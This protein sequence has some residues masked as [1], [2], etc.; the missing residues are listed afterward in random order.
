MPQPNTYPQQAGAT[1]NF[2]PYPTGN[3]MF[4][5]SNPYPGGQSNTTP[6]PTGAQNTPYPPFMPNTGGYN[7]SYVSFISVIFI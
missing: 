5:G 1:S 6:Y 7:T 2:P 4:G 3:N